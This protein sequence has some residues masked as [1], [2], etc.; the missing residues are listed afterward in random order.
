MAENSSNIT[1]IQNIFAGEQVAKNFPQYNYRLR[2]AGLTE[3]EPYV[4]EAPRVQEETDEQYQARILT[5]GRLFEEQEILLDDL[6]HSEQ[7]IL[8]LQL[9]SQ[10]LDGKI[11]RTLLFLEKCKLVNDGKEYEVDSRNLND[12]GCVQHGSPFVTSQC[13]A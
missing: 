2:L 9:N 8:N 3:F 6:V 4:S 11:P 13:R 1:F 7:N 5:S 10:F 12:L